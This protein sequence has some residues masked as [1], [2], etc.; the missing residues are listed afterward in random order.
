MAVRN[1]RRQL[2]CAGVRTESSRSDLIDALAVG[3]WCC[4]LLVD[5]LLYLQPRMR[6]E[7][8]MHALQV[9]FMPRQA[10][11]P[12]HAPCLFMHVNV[13]RCA[14]HAVMCMRMKYLHCISCGGPTG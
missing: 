9:L 5:Q 11:M 8:S 6:P 14:T 13:M 1:A 2:A 12:R 7:R 4:V 10:C 3:R